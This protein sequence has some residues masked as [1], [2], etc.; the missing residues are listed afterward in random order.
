[1]TM[2]LLLSYFVL[3]NATLLLQD[4]ASDT[5]GSPQDDQ[6]LRSTSM[7]NNIYI[8]TYIHLLLCAV[9][10]FDYSYRQVCKA[11]AIACSQRPAK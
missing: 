2:L 9:V 8:Y 6:L 4:L 10:L 5:I 3:Q 7:A 1:M 11:P